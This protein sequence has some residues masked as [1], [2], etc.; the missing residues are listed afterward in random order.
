MV[1]DCIP[2]GHNPKGNKCIFVDHMFVSTLYHY[3]IEKHI[4]GKS[5]QEGLAKVTPRNLHVD[6]FSLA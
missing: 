4:G 6:G 3:S 5:R 2:S 1:S